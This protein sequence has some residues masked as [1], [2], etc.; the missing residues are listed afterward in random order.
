MYK[1]ELSIILKHYRIFL[2][3]AQGVSWPGGWASCPLSPISVAFWAPHDPLSKL[4][5]GFP[6]A[7]I[8]LPILNT[9]VVTLGFLLPFSQRFISKILVV[10]AKRGIFHSPLGLSL[11]LHCYAVPELAHFFYSNQSSCWLWLLRHGY[12]PVETLREGFIL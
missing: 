10:K 4:S 8:Q 3:N 11:H 12:N 9:A 6:L 2:L 5:H 7:K 1:K